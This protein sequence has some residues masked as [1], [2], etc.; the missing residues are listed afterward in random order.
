MHAARPLHC[1][2]SGPGEHAVPATLHPQDPAVQSVNMPMRRYLHCSNERQQS[3]RNHVQLPV[4]S[5]S[6]CGMRTRQESSDT[7]SAGWF[8]K[9]LRM[10]QMSASPASLPSSLEIWRTTATPRVT[11]CA[12]QFFLHQRSLPATPGPSND[13]KDSIVYA[14]RR[15]LRFAT[16]SAPSPCQTTSC[17]HPRSRA[18]PLKGL[19]GHAA[20]LHHRIPRSHVG[21]GL[22][23]VL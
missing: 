4:F 3:Q 17:H 1:R 22:P 21:E 5:R 9:R 10:V 8:A 14:S 2:P 20:R 18:L 15:S 16:M 12:S 6:F 19:R 7:K 11:L 13:F 23:P